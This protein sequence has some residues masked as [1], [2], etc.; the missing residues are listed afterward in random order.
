MLTLALT[1]TLALA[2]PLIPN[3]RTAG[4]AERRQCGAC[5]LYGGL[6]T[7]AQHGLAQGL[8]GTEVQRVR[9]LTRLP[10]GLQLREWSL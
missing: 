7:V 4:A 1:L 9:Q 6:E 8:D 3:Q 10:A 2:L 5:R